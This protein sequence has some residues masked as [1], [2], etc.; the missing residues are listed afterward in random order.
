MVVRAQG[1]AEGRGG[2]AVVKHCSK[3]SNKSSSKSSSATCLA[4]EWLCERKVVPNA[5]EVGGGQYGRFCD[6]YASTSALM[7]YYCF[8]FCFTTALLM[9]YYCF[10]TGGG[11]HYGRFC[12]GYASISARTLVALRPHTPLAQGLIHQQLKASHT[13]SLRPHTLVAEGLMHRWGTLWARL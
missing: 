2:E 1:G 10:T 7:R 5:E 12:D 9:L 4:G 13:S 8:Y 6:G 3:I 11:G